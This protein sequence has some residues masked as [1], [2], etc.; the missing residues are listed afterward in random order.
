VHL[1][2]SGAWAN[3]QGTQAGLQSP[4]PAFRYTFLPVLNE[5]WSMFSSY[6][7]VALLSLALTVPAGVTA[8][9]VPNFSG[10]W[11]LQVDKSDFGMM[12]GP[13]SR[14]DIIDHQEPKITIKRTASSPQMGEIKADLMYVVD[15]KPYKNTVGPQEAT[16]TLHWEGQVLVIVSE[17]N[18]PQGQATLTDR[19]T[20]SADGKTLTQVRTIT[21]GG[22]EFTQ[23]AVFSKQ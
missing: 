20:L 13:T 21:A 6:R 18:T 10:T 1:N 8:Q 7:A 5:G 11:V 2:F 9:A 4:V 22:Q 19:W 14:T 17:V 16:S 12:P 15:G 23:T 3:R